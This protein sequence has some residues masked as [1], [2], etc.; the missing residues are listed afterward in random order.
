MLKRKDT[1]RLGEKL[2]GEHLKKKGYRIL[3]TNYRCRTGEIDIVARHQGDLVFIE[4]RTKANLEFGTPE[5]SITEAKMKHLRSAANHYIQ[6]RNYQSDSWRID[7][8]VLELTGKN[9]LKRIEVIENA[10][11][12]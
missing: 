3:E 7:V 6:E 9:K 12:E 10:V 4:V 5:E 8:V 2:A 11:E 1:G